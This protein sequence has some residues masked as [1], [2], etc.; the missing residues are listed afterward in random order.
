[1]IGLAL[2]MLVSTGCA[3]SMG[4]LQP[5]EDVTTLFQSREWVETYQYYHYSDGLVSRSTSVIIGIMA[6]YFVESRV[7]RQIEDQEELHSI[8]NDT[9][10]ASDSAPRGFNIINPDGKR[11]GIWYSSA[12]GTSVRFTSDNRV[13]PMVPPARSGPD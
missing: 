3:R 9:Q 1:M 4:S 5:D 8:I 6:P 2:I 10:L 13:I 11:V 7:W 12:F